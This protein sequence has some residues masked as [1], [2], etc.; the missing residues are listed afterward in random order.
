MYAKSVHRYIQPSANEL[1]PIPQVLTFGFYFLYSDPY[2]YHLTGCPV[3]HTNRPNISIL[4]MTYIKLLMSRRVS[5]TTYNTITFPCPNLPSYQI[6]SFSKK[7]TRATCLIS[8]LTG[9][10]LGVF[11]YSRLAGFPNDQSTEMK[12]SF[13]GVHGVV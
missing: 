6:S 2:S 11:C 1:H 7:S 5:P 13:Q 10:D 9:R 8:H 3:I 4:M 12:F